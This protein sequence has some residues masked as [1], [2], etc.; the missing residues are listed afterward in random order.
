MAARSLVSVRRLLSSAAAAP[1]LRALVPR[2]GGSGSREQKHDHK[3]RGIG[4]CRLLSAV[5]GAGVLTWRWH[6]ELHLQQPPEQGVGVSQR[7]QGSRH[8]RLVV[9][10]LDGTLLNPAGQVSDFTKEVLSKVL[11]DEA[12]APTM[13]IA[14][15][16]QLGE[17]PYEQVPASDLY[18]LTS[19]GA[20]VSRFRRGSHGEAGTLETVSSLTLSREAVA[21]FLAAAAPGMCDAVWFSYAHGHKYPVVVIYT[22]EGL[23]LTQG[24]I[25]EF[26]VQT[27]LSEDLH[28]EVVSC[29]V[30]TSEPERWVRYATRM[31]PPE[32]FVLSFEPEAIVAVGLAGVNKGVALT[33]LCQKLGLCM[34][35]AV[36]FGDAVNDLEMLAAV[37]RGCAPSN[38]SEKVKRVAHVVL[39]HSNAEDAVARALLA[40]HADGELGPGAAPP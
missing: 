20:Q 36:A 35:Q 3:S 11:A 21:A 33:Q 40:M 1:P 38:A 19:N 37:G 2:A 25:D 27:Q 17:V 5:G 12:S 26:R 15:G 4:F 7:R 9:S 22:A 10:D 16:R 31:L 6:S 23:K 29:G 8:F 13:V 30:I 14:T 18:L 39:P 32:L 28:G 34:S 24:I